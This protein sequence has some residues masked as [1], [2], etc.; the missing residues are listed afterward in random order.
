MTV[1]VKHFRGPSRRHRRCGN[2]HTCRPVC[3]VCTLTRLKRRQLRRDQRTLAFI[4]MT[5]MDIVIHHKANGIATAEG[6]EFWLDPGR[7][8][9]SISV[10]A[11]KDRAVK[12][13]D[14][15]VLPVLFDRGDQL[16]KF[17]TLNERE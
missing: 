17:L 2:F 13:D 5:A 9:R 11:I 8:A 7:K 1:N 16:V 12:R 3:I 14:R 6:L 4:E 15:I 10:A